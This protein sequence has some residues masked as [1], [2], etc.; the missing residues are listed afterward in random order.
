MRATKNTLLLFTFFLS[1]L[2]LLTSIS[3]KAQT[4][5]RV[6]E[7]TNLLVYEENFLP[8]GMYCEALAFN[9][10]PNL[11]EQIAAG[12]FNYIYAESYMKPPH[13]LEAYLSDYSDF[14]NDCETQ[15]INV[16]NGLLW[17]IVN[18]E[19]FTTYINALKPHLA[20]ICWNLMDDANGQGIDIVAQQKEEL[21]A[22][23]SSRVTSI[24]FYSNEPDAAYMLPLTEVGYM[25]SYPWQL[26]G[27][28]Y[29]LSHSDFLFRNHVLACQDEHVVPI[30]TPQTYA[31]DLETYPSPEHVDCQTYLAFITGMKGVLYYTFKDYGNNSTIDVSQPQVFEAASRV[32]NEIL[33]TEWQEVILHGEHQYTNMG[34]YRYYATW[35]YNNALYLIAVNASHHNTYS[36]EIPLPEEVTGEPIHFF[37]YRPNSLSLQNGMLSGDLQ[38]YQVAIYK[39]E[40]VSGIPNDGGDIT[41]IHSFPNPAENTFYL[42]GIQPPYQIQ[43]YNTLGTCVA[44]EHIYNDNGEITVGQLTNGVYFM[45]VLKE[46][47]KKYHSVKII[48][49]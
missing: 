8:F 40:T 2:S 25:Q 16:V 48:K 3:M 45:E 21:M 15:N 39:M 41:E 4:V 35:R 31:W 32:A 20:L 12:G 27:D 38:P 28:N 9:E 34:Q 37:D 11:A 46:G 30:A 26:D 19:L 17:Y 42:S 49:N 24:S 18:D 1:F 33:Q 5:S 22:L 14:L 47:G 29:D 43:I 10:N 36:Y 6:D 7:N 23:D 44:E 13:E